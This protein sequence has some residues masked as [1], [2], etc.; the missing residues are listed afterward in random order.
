M[1]WSK[2]ASAAA[3]LRA[4]L[5]LR[6]SGASVGPLP[7]LRGQVSVHNAGHLDIGRRLLLDSRGFRTQLA[8]GSG[9]TLRIGDDVFI[10]QGADI[11]AAVLV[12]IGDRVLLGPHVTIVDDS[13]HDVAPDVPRRVAPVVVEDDV[14]LGRRCIVMPGVTIGRFSVVGAGAVVTKDVPP[15]SVVVGMPARV[16]RT[17]EPPPPG[18]RR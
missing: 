3:V 18:F 15:C 10:N 4:T 2:S 5:L 12:Q 6:A 7:R 16:V 9:G 8:V 13:A 17:F 11:W 1:P 14:W